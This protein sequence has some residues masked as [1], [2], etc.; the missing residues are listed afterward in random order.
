M[1]T[2]QEKDLEK[3]ISGVHVYTRN[4]AAAASLIAI[5]ARLR[6]Q[7]PVTATKGAGR[8]D[9]LLFWF[10]N[11]EIECAGTKRPVAGWLTLFLC[12]WS[13]FDLPL[14]HPAAFLK[15]SAENRQILVSAA[16]TAQAHPFKIVQRHN[17]IAVLGPALSEDD[18]RRLLSQ[19]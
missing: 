1:P 4:I 14:E 11:G 8:G 6:P 10:E 7:M 15:A 13:D 2:A 18:A 16:K 5:G 17:R 19:G 3:Q 12:P 9:D